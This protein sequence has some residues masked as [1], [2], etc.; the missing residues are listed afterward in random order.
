MT[1]HTAPPLTLAIEGMTCASCVLRVEKALKKVAGVADATVN[2]ATETAT[3]QAAPGTLPSVL[4]AAVHA[5]GYEAHLQP[6]TGPAAPAAPSEAA[7]GGPV[8]AAAL[9]SAPLL[10]PMLGMAWGSHWMLPGWW[11]WL[12]ATPVQFWLGARFYR[13][14]WAALRSGSAPIATAGTTSSRPARSRCR[15]SRS[16]ATR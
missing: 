16:A 10:L 2:L 11:Q 3:V 15:R 4:E 9:L 7:H 14:G 13:H 5:A 12:L 6:E 8:L 1:T